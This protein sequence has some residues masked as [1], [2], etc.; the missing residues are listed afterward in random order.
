[1]TRSA[2]EFGGGKRVA[3]EGPARLVNQ[4]GR[5]QGH[6]RVKFQG[7]ARHVQP[8]VGVGQPQHLRRLR[9]V[10]GVERRRTRQNGPPFPEQYLKEFGDRRHA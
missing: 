2:L 10:F 5:R 6:V 7:R 8:V 3:D 9:P 1:M 4:H